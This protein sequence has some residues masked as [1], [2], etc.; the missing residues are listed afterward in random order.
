MVSGGGL[1]V[2]HFDRQY[3]SKKKVKRL[4]D[5]GDRARGPINLPA[6]R[7]GLQPGEH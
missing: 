7:V 4:L 3:C 1:Q 2:K 5:A 6:N